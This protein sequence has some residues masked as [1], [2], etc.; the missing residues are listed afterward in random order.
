MTKSCNQ[1]ISFAGDLWEYVIWMSVELNVVIIVSSVPLLR[2]L[3]R[4][5]S[6]RAAK[7]LQR[8]DGIPLGSVF[9]K[10]GSRS[11]VSEITNASQEDLTK[12]AGSFPGREGEGITVTQEVEIS[13]ESHDAPFVHAALVGLVQGEISKRPSG[14]PTT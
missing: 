9:S 10:K 12:S 13:Y 2:P 3:F 7:Y 14:K 8:F 6:A 4:R 11:G 5:Q 1:L